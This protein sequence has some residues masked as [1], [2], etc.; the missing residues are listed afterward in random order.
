MTTAT[1]IE[2]NV[3][4]RYTLLTSFTT[5][6][7]RFST[8]FSFKEPCVK[9]HLIVNTRF[10][11]FGLFKVESDLEVNPVHTIADILEHA[12]VGHEKVT[13]FEASLTTAEV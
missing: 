13:V 4:R 10:L 5:Y 12:L 9:K 2:A 1:D 7:S 11:L 6:F 3:A 8:V